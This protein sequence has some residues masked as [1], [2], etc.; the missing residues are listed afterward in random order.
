VIYLYG[1]L[2]CNNHWAPYE[3][4]LSGGEDRV[5]TQL[6]GSLIKNN[7]IKEQASGKITAGSDLEIHGEFNLG[8]ATLE[9]DNFSLIGVLPF[10]FHNGRIEGDFEIKGN[11][12]VWEDQTH[13]LTMEGLITVT[14]TLQG[15]E[16]GGGT[17]Y[18]N[19]LVEGDIINNGVIKDNDNQDDR[20][21]INVTGDISNNSIWENSITNFTGAS[22][23][24]ISQAAGKYFKKDLADLDS[25]SNVIANTDIT[26]L[27]NIDLNRS[28]LDMNGY[29]LIVSGQLYDGYLKNAKLKNGFLSNLRLLGNDELNGK[30]ETGDYVD[31]V[32]SIIVNDTLSCTSYGGGTYTYN[33]RFYG[34]FENRGFIGQLY[35]DLLQMKINGNI[36]NKGSWT[37]YQNYFLFYENYNECSVR[38]F[39]TGSTNIQ[40]NGSTI[41]GSG[42][43]AFTIISGGGVQTIAPNESYDLT[44]QFN[45]TGGDT[46]A[47][48]TIDCNEIGTLNTIYLVGHNYETTVDVEEQHFAG[49]APENFTLYQNYPNPFNPSTTL[50]FVIGQSSFVSLKIY[51]VLGREVA[52]LV[53]EY[54]PAGSYEVEFDV[55]QDSSPDIAIR[56]TPTLSSGVYFYQLK[57]GEFIQTKKMIYLK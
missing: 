41:T 23:Q 1:D 17:I 5:I 53:D 21:R 44:I 25:L 30:V 9:V 34:T 27:G 15:D 38:L 33:I 26:V 24:Y 8:G 52:T 20:L 14:D 19:L 22:P 39:N 43:N 31:A 57:A 4:Y 49:I 46:I 32:A 3:T 51:D 45:P 48:L 42:A 47:T 11:F 7:V 54:K 10:N 56:Q 12:L 2:T 18:Y 50:L 37:A 6:A 29:Q 55:G 36:I 40:F 16:H 13:P 28:Q 35:D